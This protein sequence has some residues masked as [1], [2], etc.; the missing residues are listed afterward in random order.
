MPISNAVIIALYF[1]DG[2]TKCRTWCYTVIS[3][4]QH[5]TSE[6]AE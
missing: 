2:M 1:S 6:K 3:A 5:N 4:L